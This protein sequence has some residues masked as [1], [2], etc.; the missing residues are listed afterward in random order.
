[1]NFAFIGKITE[2]YLSLHCHFL[3]K[4]HHI[5]I[6]TTVDALLNETFTNKFNALIIDYNSYPS[7]YNHKLVQFLKVIYPDIPI[8]IFIDANTT[9]LFS[10]DSIDCIEKTLPIEEIMQKICM[11]HVQ[12][13]AIKSPLIHLGK[14][15][16]FDIQSSL[17]YYKNVIQPL[18]KKEVVFL[19]ILI[20]RGKEFTA[21]QDILQLIYPNKI[22]K[23]VAIRSVIMRLRKKLKEEIIETYPG[24]GYRLKALSESI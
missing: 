14:D 5:Q 2:F 16:I 15:Y 19:Q 22:I 6:Y 20:R 9:N 24:Y 3:E 4:N 11:T 10:L 8:F 13:E 12:M 23:D 7:A 17:L 21:L 18:T 1:M